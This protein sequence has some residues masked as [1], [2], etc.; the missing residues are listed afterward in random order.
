MLLPLG[1]VRMLPACEVEGTPAV[2]NYP[3]GEEFSPLSKEKLT[4]LISSLIPSFPEVWMYLDAHRL[5]RIHEERTIDN[6]IQ[7]AFRTIPYRFPTEEE[8]RDFP[9]NDCPAYAFFETDPFVVTLDGSIVDSSSFV[10]DFMDK[11]KPE[12]PLHLAIKKHFRSGGQD[13]RNRAYN[14]YCNIVKAI[15]GKIDLSTQG[16]Y[17]E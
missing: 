5:G 13:N 4:L 15:H 9:P 7:K 3:P 2:E 14:E 1:L 17:L 16:R 8:I 11:L 10:K 12:D 6:A